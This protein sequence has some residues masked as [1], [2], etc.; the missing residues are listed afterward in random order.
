MPAKNA[1]ACMAPRTSTDEPAR[2]QPSARAPLPQPNSVAYPASKRG[3][4]AQPP[5][6]TVKIAQTQEM[7]RDLLRSFREGVA[8]EAIVPVASCSPRAQQ[9]RNSFRLRCRSTAGA[10]EE[11][12]RAGGM[13]PVLAQVVLLLV[14]ICWGVAMLPVKFVKVIVSDEPP[15]C[16][17][18]PRPSTRPGLELAYSASGSSP[19]WQSI[20]D[21]LDSFTF[22]PDPAM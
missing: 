10:S 20:F 19:V 17:P 5:P 1:S 15:W 21:V 2:T 14:N 7:H 6:L 12:L 3:Q 11:P 8:S 18:S 22:D 4:R 16:D 9:L 13:L